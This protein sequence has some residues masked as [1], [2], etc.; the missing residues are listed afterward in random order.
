MLFS[1]ITKL[2]KENIMTTS[3]WIFMIGAWGIITL[4]TIYCFIKVFKTDK[5]EKAGKK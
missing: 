5:E 1:L 3:G 2:K 4:L